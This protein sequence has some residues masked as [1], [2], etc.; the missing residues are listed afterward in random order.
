[1]NIQNLNFTV[2]ELKILAEN[3]QKD[4]IYAVGYYYENGIRTSVNLAEAAV[5]YEKA[6]QKGHAEAAMRLALLYAQ[7]KGVEKNEK[8]AF[9]YI[10]T[11]SI[12]R[13]AVM[14]KGLG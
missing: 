11:L 1:M 5:W 9:T 8:K 12:M 14:R 13:D 10:P 7:G 6:A 4:F 2:E 3:G